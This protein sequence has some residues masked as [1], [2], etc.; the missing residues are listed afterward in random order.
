MEHA[1]GRIALPLVPQGKS[2]VVDVSDG[3]L[4]DTRRT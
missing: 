4:L 1:L 3:A 2:A